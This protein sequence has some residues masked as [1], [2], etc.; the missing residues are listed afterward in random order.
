MF[1]KGINCINRDKS[2]FTL[3]QKDATC[4]SNYSNSTQFA[5]FL[6]S[7]SY[8]VSSLFKKYFR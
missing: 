4:R 8:K 6:V 5:R 7:I 2:I 3:R 1:N